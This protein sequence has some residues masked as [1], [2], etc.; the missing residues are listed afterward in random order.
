VPA[1]IAIAAASIVT[2]PIGAKWA[3][4]LDELHLKRLFG[5]YLIIVSLSMNYKAIL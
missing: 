4:N 1:L 5:I 3:H 2:A